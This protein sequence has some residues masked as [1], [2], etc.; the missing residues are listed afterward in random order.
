MKKI[1]FI[2]I[3]GF[4]FLIME[5]GMWKSSQWL[6]TNKDTKT[7]NILEDVLDK[8]DNWNTKKITKK[9]Q[10]TLSEEI[11]KK[12][13]A[14]DSNA[15]DELEELIEAFEK[16]PEMKEF[17]EDYPN[18]KKWMEK[19]IELKNSEIESGAP[20]FL[21]WDRRWG[22]SRYGSKIIAINGCGPT[23]LAMVYVGL[24][25]DSKMNPKQMALY[26][27]KCGYITEG[28]GTDWGLMTDGAKALGL[29]AEEMALDENVMLNTLR[30]GCQIICSMRPGDFTTTGHFI[31]IYGERD[32]K[33]LIHDPNS[34]ERS[35]KEWEFKEIKGQIKNLWKY[36]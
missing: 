24:R 31:V 8:I 23:C 15:V 9:L 1:K 12:E 25:G 35:E 14:E 18:R 7:I 36:S 4:I 32:G 34:V 2:L 30:S 22:Y 27:E 29:N 21:Q 26:S 13:G 6:H 5:F 11:K 17:V 10:Q 28:S 20:L 3:T 33:L 19:E 16:N